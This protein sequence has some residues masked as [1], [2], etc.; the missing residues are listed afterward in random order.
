MQDLV[1]KSIKERTSEWRILIEEE[2]LTEEKARAYI[3]RLAVDVMSI[4]NLA[5]QLQYDVI[6]R[7]SANK[8][9]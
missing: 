1:N 7:E 6:K 5:I 4:Y 3:A 2:G 8:R 9:L